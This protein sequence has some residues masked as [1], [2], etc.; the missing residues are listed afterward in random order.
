MQSAQFQGEQLPVDF[1]SPSGVS[2][3]YSSESFLS[4]CSTVLLKPVS[5]V[6]N[7]MPL[8]HSAATN[9]SHISVPY[10]ERTKA[11]C[12]SNVVIMMFPKIVLWMVV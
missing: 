11:D 7:V 9:S 12:M 3:Q 5:M 2:K 4:G 10:D 1:K 8:M 6:L